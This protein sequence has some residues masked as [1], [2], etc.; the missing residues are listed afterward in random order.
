MCPGLPTS[1]MIYHLL[2]SFGS[3]NGFRSADT[4]RGMLTQSE[5]VI[6]VLFYN[7]DVIIDPETKSI[8]EIILSC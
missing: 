8:K 6:D 3:N 5:P 1:I 4:L 7:L 2:N